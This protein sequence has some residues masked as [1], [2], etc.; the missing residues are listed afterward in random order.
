MDQCSATFF[1]DVRHE[2]SFLFLLLLT[3]PDKLKR[4]KF[5]NHEIK[6][7]KI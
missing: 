6:I 2:R 5:T 1:E 7:I 4:A 3:D